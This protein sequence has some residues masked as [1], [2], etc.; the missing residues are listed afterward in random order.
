ME[1]PEK[2]RLEFEYYLQK[3]FP[4]P[5]IEVDTPCYS[6]DRDLFDLWEDLPE[7]ARWGVYVDFFDSVG[8]LIEIT[9]CGF[10]ND[11][12]YNE[13]FEYEI[14]S[15]VIAVCDHRSD[16]Y[17]TRHEA[18]KAALEKAVEIYNQKTNYEC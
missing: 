7:S 5:I 14:S 6:T 16:E 17:E 4:K 8:M 9:R 12:V 18:R 2:V 11:A 10:G 1:L 3:N 15:G 13:R